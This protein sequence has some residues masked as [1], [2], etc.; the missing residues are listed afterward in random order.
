MTTIL[1]RIFGPTPKYSLFRTC[2]DGYLT[3]WLTE[4]FEGRY[5]SMVWKPVGAGARGGKATAQEWRL[6]DSMTGIHRT[7]RQAKAR[8]ARIWRQ[9]EEKGKTR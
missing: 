8:A 3:G 1:D 5:A 2:A 9:H 7:K 6:I 4:P